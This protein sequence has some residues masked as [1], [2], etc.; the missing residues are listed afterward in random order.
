MFTGPEGGPL[1]YRNFEARAWRPALRRLGLPLV[2]LHVL[3]HSAAAA[4]IAAEGSPKAVQ[5]ILGHA[6]AAFTLTTYGH[7]FESDLDALAGR[8]DALVREAPATL[9]RPTTGVESL[10]AGQK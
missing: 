9:L 2:G 4:L 5:T 6:S 3:R 7:M 1:R 10:T 8:L